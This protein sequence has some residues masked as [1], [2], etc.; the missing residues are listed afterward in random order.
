MKFWV[1]VAGVV[2]FIL[3]SMVAFVNIKQENIKI[4]LLYSNSGTM[5]TSEIPVAQ[6]FKTSIDEINKNGGIKNRQIEVLEFDGKSDPKEFQKGASKLID[7]GAIAIFGCW[8]SASRKM[9]KEVVEKHNNILFYPVQYEGAESSPNIVY[10]GLSANQ[11][12]NPTISYIKNNFGKKIYLIGSDYVYPKMANVYIKTLARMTDLQVVQERYKKLGDTDFEQIAREIKALKPDAVINTIN[13]DS[14]IAFFNSLHKEGVGLNKTPVFS[15]SVDE[16]LVKVIGQKI[17]YEALE[18]HYITAGY[19]DILS[20][21]KKEIFA[22]FKNKTKNDIQITDA[23]FSMYVAVELFRSTLFN[24]KDISTQSLSDNLKRAS[25]NIL[26]NIFFI[27][28]NNNHIHKNVFI[29]KAS[30]DGRLNIVW[31]SKNIVAPKPYPEF[32]EKEF[33]ENELDKIYKNYQN[34]WEAK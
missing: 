32:K 33:W 23:M 28:K 6:I 17:G 18:G 10:L 14:N 15:L 4:G 34:S 5:A 9:V 3:A 22:N 11:Q 31:R 12:I 1:I 26:D 25:F 21:G 2:V 13:G 30:K 7:D 24:S 20:Q 27:D 16:A 29:A 19:F 8:T